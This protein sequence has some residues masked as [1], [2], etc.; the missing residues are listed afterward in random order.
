MKIYLVG[1]AVRDQLLGLPVNEKDWVVVGTTPEEMLRL[2]FKQVG[3]DF[4]VF[5]HP[6]THEE[7]A[8][9]RTERKIGRGYTGFAFNTSPNVTL[10]DDLKRRDLTINAMA[11]TPEGAIVDP[12]HGAS[13][14]KNKI[15]RH[16]SPAF[17]ED[18]V[19]VLR[20][21]RFAA[22]FRF[23]V[24]PDT[25]L[26]MK[27]MV[28]N[29]EVDTL[30]P[31]RVFKELDRALCENFPEEFFN[32][33][34]AVRADQV[35]FPELQSWSALEKAIPL[36]TKSS[37]RFAALTASLSLDNYLKL[38]N[39]YRLP[40]EYRELGEMVIKYFEP[41]QH[42]ENLNDAEVVDLLVRLDVFRRE[43]RFQDFI[44]ACRACGLKT[45][46]TLQKYSEAAK[47]IDVKKITEDK[48]L[49][50][51]AISDKI[52]EKR[53]DVIASLRSRRGNP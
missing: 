5:L 26:L 20:V 42:V 48:N 11:E 23:T 2:G 34:H 21:A 28:E 12:Y 32:V 22:R 40:T 52:F 8:L 30:V 13:D 29:G 51:K 17:S 46:D 10:E 35:L 33:L 43:A 50:G 15:L 19:R 25:I 38:C 44:V 18:P 4:P 27:K 1:G 9:A 53:M 41:C 16:V 47:N 49:S 3:K 45:A 36:S 7:Y 6:E 39:R 31:E 24:A 37:V 14:L